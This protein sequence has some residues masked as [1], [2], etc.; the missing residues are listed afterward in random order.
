MLFLLLI[1][2]MSSFFY[3]QFPKDFINSINQ[4]L[5]LGVRTRVLR[6]TCILAWVTRQ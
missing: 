6:D 1:R 3:L 4:L 2:E 5:L